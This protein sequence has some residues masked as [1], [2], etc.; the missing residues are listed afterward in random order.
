[1]AWNDIKIEL[2]LSFIDK[3]DYKYRI[4]NIIQEI[5]KHFGNFIVKERTSNRREE[6][7]GVKIRK[8]HYTDDEVLRLVKKYG[9]L[10]Y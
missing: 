8:K 7:V 6:Y 2:R 3:T 10:L 5:D 4:S 9:L 1:M